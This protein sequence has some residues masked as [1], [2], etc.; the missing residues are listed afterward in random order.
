MARK[1]FRKRSITTVNVRYRILLTKILMSRFQPLLMQVQLCKYSENRSPCIAN[2]PNR[3]PTLWKRTA[4]QCSAAPS[5]IWKVRMYISGNIQRDVGDGCPRQAVA[6]WHAAVHRRYRR[7]RGARCAAE[8]MERRICIGL[9]LWI[10][11]EALSGGTKPSA[12]ST[13]KPL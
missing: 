3:P 7:T 5:L 10:G 1:S 6:G 2:T 9:L 13:L 8:L 12:C 11:T 4:G